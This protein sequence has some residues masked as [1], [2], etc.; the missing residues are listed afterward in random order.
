M[1]VNLATRCSG[2]PKGL[3]MNNFRGSIEPIS[4]GYPTLIL[5]DG[6]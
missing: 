4:M 1:T 6:V 5:K 3:V 2:L